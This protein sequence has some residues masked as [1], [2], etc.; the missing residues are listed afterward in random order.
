MRIHFVFSDLPADH[1]CPVP[2]G[3]P[4]HQGCNAEEG[5][6]LFDF[7]ERKVFFFFFFFFFSKFS[8]SL[9]NST[10]DTMDFLDVARRWAEEAAGLRES[11]ASTL[12]ASI[13]RSPPLNAPSPSATAAH[14]PSPRSAAVHAASPPDRSAPESLH[15][16]VSRTV[17]AEARSLALQTTLDRYVAQSEVMEVSPF[18]S[19]FPHTLSLSFTP[20]SFFSPPRLLA[21]RSAKWRP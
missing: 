11:R 16:A 20:F 4:P 10:T 1:H 9:D 3:W 5:T 14:V 18:P 7:F 15:E 2:G 12:G 13:M 8:L 17:A 6:Q 19:F 21:L